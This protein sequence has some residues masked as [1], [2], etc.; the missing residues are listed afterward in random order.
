MQVQ[1][2]VCDKIKIEEKR[3]ILGKVINS[4]TIPVFPY[5]VKFSVLIKISNIPTDQDV[6]TEF[7]VVN[8]L[9]QQI[10]SPSNYVHRNYRDSKHIPGVDQN[11]DF[12]L[13]VECEENIF[14]EC[15]INGNKKS[16][17]PIN[18]SLC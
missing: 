8:G 16:Y 13:L 15:F 10:S 11:F 3:H 14:L 5:I 12:T 2:V 9:G 18:I 1:L 6:L 7:K 4:I 17:Y